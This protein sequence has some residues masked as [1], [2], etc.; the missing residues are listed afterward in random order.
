MKINLHTALLL[1][2]ALL[3]TLAL[4]SPIEEVEPQTEDLEERSLETDDT[5]EAT[6]PSPNAFF[7]ARSAEA[8]AIPEAAPNPNPEANPQDRNRPNCPKPD[9]CLDWDFRDCKCKKQK[10]PKPHDC[11]DWDYRE[12]SVSVESGSAR[13]LTSV[14]IGIIR[15]VIAEDGSVL[16][17]TS[18]ETGTTGD[19]TVGGGSAPS[20]IT[21][22]TGTTRVVG[23]GIGTE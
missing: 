13:S 11:R 18:V 8:E 23:V 4:G 3:F 20:R 21:A 6:D 16:S 9:S 7:E 10:C 5:V 14:V 12:W 15:D 19:V 2:F 17:L 1:V 22:V